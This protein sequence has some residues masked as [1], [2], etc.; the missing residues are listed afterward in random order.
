ML[1]EYEIIH[2][3]IKNHKWTIIIEIIDLYKKIIALIII[4]KSKKYQKEQG[5]QFLQN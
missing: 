3:Q 1:I 5:V 2:F 4:L